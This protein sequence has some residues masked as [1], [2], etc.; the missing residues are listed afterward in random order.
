MDM[1]NQWHRF[2]AMFPQAPARKAGIFGLVFEDKIIHGAVSRVANYPGKGF[3]DDGVP[4]QDPASALE[5]LNQ[6]YLTKAMTL[7]DRGELLKVLLEMPL[8]KSDVPSDQLY[9]RQLEQIRA[10]MGLD[11]HRRSLRVDHWG[12]KPMADFFPRN[13]FLFMLLRNW[14]VDL[15][16]ERR[17]VLVGILDEDKRELEALVLEM[18]GQAIERVIDPDWSGFD[19][20]SELKGFVRS[21]EAARFVQ[22]CESKYMLPSYATFFTREAWDEA[23]KLDAE[24]GGRAAWRHLWK[25]RRG[26]ELGKQVLFEPEPWP[27]KAAWAW[28][29]LRG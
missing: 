29:A 18:N 1:Q 14:I 4:V 2:R 27:L 20:R 7:L 6:K 16:P 9:Y 12:M 8:I 25:A 24:Q 13:H 10:A 15:L 3:A 19:W 21:Q 23:V 11:G 28:L 5:R 26:G 17:L 22:W